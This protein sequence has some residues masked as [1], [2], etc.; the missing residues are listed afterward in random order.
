MY[1]KGHAY[2]RTTFL[3]L[4]GQIRDDVQGQFLIQALCHNMYLVARFTAVYS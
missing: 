2:V 4:Q 1:A 3:T